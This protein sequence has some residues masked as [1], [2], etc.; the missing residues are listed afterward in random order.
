MVEIRFD[1]IG[2]QDR[3][4]ALSVLREQRP[5]LGLGHQAWKKEASKRMAYIRC[6]GDPWSPC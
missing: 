2:E 1:H 6:L 3:S 5:A 4:L